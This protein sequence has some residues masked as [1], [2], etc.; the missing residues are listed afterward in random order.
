MLLGCIG[1]DFTGSSDIANTLAKA[2]MAVTQF[3]GVP[4]E[5]AEKSVE[6]GVV[7][8]KSRTIPVKQAVD[9]SLA[10]LDWL[11]AQGCRQIVFKYC[12][13]FD[14]TPEGNIGP[15]AQALGERMGETAVLVCP[16]FP[17]NG[18]SVYQGHLFVNDCLLSE[19]GMR[20]H[21]LTP[22]TDSDIRR[23]LA[24]QTDWPVKHIA[25]NVVASGHGAILEALNTHSGA[26]VVADA[27][28]D[29][30]LL[31]LGRAVSERKLITGGS[32]IA[33][34]LPDNF[35]RSGLLGS[36]GIDWS[37]TTGGGAVLCGSC[38]EATR[39]QIAYHGNDHPVREMDVDAL[40]NGQLDPQPVA[41]WMLE[42]Q[43]QH[44]LIYTSADPE[45]VREM[46][47][48]YGR[49][50]TA[51]SVEN[52]L[53]SVARTMRDQGLR[54]IVTAGGETSGAIVEGLDVAQLE[55]GP[56][57]APGVPA[58]RDPVSGVHLALKSGNFGQD[59][60]FSRAMGVLG[61]D[62]DR[63]SGAAE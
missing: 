23:W 27:I 52:F 36:E 38:S 10:A 17:A 55:I 15:V 53:V 26:M 46:Q 4:S 25:A 44:P 48:K 42:N 54:K 31:E 47:D 58:V 14:S 13:T 50:E 12:S 63:I 21:P 61:T 51:S 30:D 24:Q 16:A 6:A 19:S 34:A 60:F 1:D 3:S 22:M 35:R 57:I 28:G 29:K 40:M 39:C 49:E 43:H 59:D 7:A 11:L 5:P 62:H 8:L 32:G 45:R 56:E 2:G 18:R 20:N 41:E 9:Q 37:G 33:L